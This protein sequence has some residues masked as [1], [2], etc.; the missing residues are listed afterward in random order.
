M[1]PLQLK[2][3]QQQM[4]CEYIDI[5][6]WNAAIMAFPLFMPPAA[7][8]FEAMSQDYHMYI[9]S[10]CH[11]KDTAQTVA[12]RDSAVLRGGIASHWSIVYSFVQFFC[13]EI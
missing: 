4:D 2:D 1:L 13:A 6:A 7:T 8:T 9:N 5:G 10:L 12:W 3:I 11:Y